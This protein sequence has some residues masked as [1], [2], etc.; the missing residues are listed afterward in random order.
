MD[1]ADALEPRFNDA[2][3]EYAQHRGFVIDPARVRHPQDKPRVE[4]GVKYV[5]GN[6]FAGEEFLGELVEARVR[7]SEHGANGGTKAPR[8]SG[9]CSPAAIPWR[10]ARADPIWTGMPGCWSD[11]I[12]LLRAGAMPELLDQTRAPSTIGTWLRSFKWSNVRE[13]DAVT[14]G[15]LARLWAAGAGPADPTGTLTVDLDSTICEVYGRTK[16]GA[17]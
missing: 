14:R 7:L 12:A 16:Q 1:R 9:R 13:L 5:R 17:D 8:W 11:D 6:F 15:L 4:N 2:F 10:V 3:G